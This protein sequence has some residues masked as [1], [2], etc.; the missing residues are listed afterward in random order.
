M[1]LQV[2]RHVL[3][4]LLFQKHFQ[5]T[6][7]LCSTVILHIWRESRLSMHAVPELSICHLLSI[8]R[9]TKYLKTFNG[10]AAHGTVVSYSVSGLDYV[11]Y[12]A[13]NRYVQSLFIKGSATQTKSRECH[14]T[15]SVT[16]RWNAGFQA[17]SDLLWMV[18]GWDLGAVDMTDNRR[19]YSCLYLAT[20]TVVLL[21]I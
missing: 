1:R 13:C 10:M 9:H 19:E 18:S 3:A 12:V 14:F 7:K 17:T 4:T 20:P 5:K 16:Q 6:S 2:W 21:N 11:L 15:K 8:N